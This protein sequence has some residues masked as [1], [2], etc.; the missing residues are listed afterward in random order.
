MAHDSTSEEVAVLRR[1]TGLPLLACRDLLRNATPD[2]RE[3]L[4]L[5]VRT[6][7][8]TNFLRDPI[9]DDPAFS[10]AFEEAGREANR[11]VEQQLAAERARLRAEG[12]SDL[13]FV[14]RYRCH[15]YWGQLKRLL[16]ERHGVDW[17]SPAE[18]NP[19]HRFD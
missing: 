13:E 16:K 3:K 15:L 11:L 12:M 18:M 5:A 6:Q 4:L 19:Y 14:L 1:K 17:L 10:A 8:G 7:D 9:E 2:L